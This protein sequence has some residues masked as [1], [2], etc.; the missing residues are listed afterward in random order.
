[1]SNF[2]YFHW[3]KHESLIFWF[4]FNMCNMN[5]ILGKNGV[6][7]GNKRFPVFLLK[8]GCHFL[9]QLYRQHHLLTISSSFFGFFSWA[10]VEQISTT[11]VSESTYF[12]SRLSEHSSRSQLFFCQK[13]LQ[14]NSFSEQGS[15]VH[16]FHSW[17]INSRLSCW[18]KD[19][20]YASTL[21]SD[22][23]ENLE[24]TQI[25]SLAG[26]SQWPG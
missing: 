6:C 10:Q 17:S 2:L 9:L 11:T 22:V 25:T 23:E 12:S 4:L 18:L 26:S 8:S 14:G 20:S 13:A 24:T 16:L 15:S 21:N 19:L 1:M 3:F 7:L 5:C